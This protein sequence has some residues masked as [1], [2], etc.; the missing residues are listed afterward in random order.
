MSMQNPCPLCNVR[1][2]K[3][4]LRLYKTPVCKKCYYGFANRR[5]FAYLID[6]VILQVLSSGVGF[7]AGTVIT[8]AMG[9]MNQQQSQMASWFF[10]GLGT[11]VGLVYGIKD[12]F[13]GKSLGKLICGVTCVKEETYE[14]AGFGASFLRN[15]VLVIPFAP[16]IVLVMMNKGHRPGDGLAKTRI[17]WDKFRDNPVFNPFAHAPAPAIGGFNFSDPLPIDTNNPYQPPST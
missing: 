17:I 10:L 7:L 3:E 2:V 13:G 14:P 11:L 12:G 4:K 16:L 1:P 15:M 9:P 8:V 6:L 5:Q